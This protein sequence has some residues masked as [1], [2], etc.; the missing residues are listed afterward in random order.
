MKLATARA[1]YLPFV[2]NER[3]CELFNA[4]YD[5]SPFVRVSLQNAKKL[6]PRL[7]PQ[8]KYWIDA[9]VDG[10]HQFPIASDT[11]RAYV[12]DY[13][14][15][16]CIADK[17]FQRKPD[18]AIVREFVTSVLDACAEL[19]PRMISVPQLPMTSDT[20]R[21]KINREMAKASS[22]WA[23]TLGNTGGIGLVLPAIFTHQTQL[24]KKTA[25]N[26]K[27]AL[28]AQC[29]EAAGATGL[30]VVDSS[31]V[32]Q[33][34]A[35]TLDLRFSSLLD[36]HQELLDRLPQARIVGGPYWGLNLVLWA[37]GLVHYPAITLGNRY[38]YH[39]PGGRVQPPSYRIALDS[40]KRLVV[41][42]PELSLWLTDA[43]KKIPGGDPANTEFSALNANFSSLLRSDNNRE[44]ICRFY[45]K[46][47]D[48]IALAPVAGRAL[49]LYQQLSSAYVLGKTLGE[50][51]EAGLA[52]RP[53]RTAQQLM[54]LCL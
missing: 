12:K 51:P 36:L 7:P 3:D 35:R 11:F 52:R 6:V 46:W 47:L 8:S 23:K 53:E 28:I 48:S 9:E 54:L 22:E 34:G 27:V 5:D 29:F 14:H 42:K 4:F 25:R 40:L 16:E 44:Q 20:S 13:K 32:D 39:I 33:E 21:N 38:R 15:Y 41:V 18:S 49:T 2:H 1:E 17:Q 26:P 50:L 30:W 45:R 31:L 19:K 10:L 24:N 43:V 37:R